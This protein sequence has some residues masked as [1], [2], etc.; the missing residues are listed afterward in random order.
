[1]DKIELF[2]FS[3]SLD[4]KLYYDTY[5][6]CTL[7]LGGKDIMGDNKRRITALVIASDSIIV[8][9]DTPDNKEPGWDAPRA[10]CVKNV[11]AF[12]TAGNELWDFDTLVG[13]KHYPI[14]LGSLLGENE[15]KVYAKFF[16]LPIIESHTFFVASTFADEHYII[17]VTD[18][19]F[20]GRV[21]HK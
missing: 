12:D 13:Q 7:W 16:H 19:K 3:V 17:D 11:F 18:R 4:K 9:T 5:L 15:K 2:Q 1:M 20:I 10:E 6:P 21:A 8:V 14:I